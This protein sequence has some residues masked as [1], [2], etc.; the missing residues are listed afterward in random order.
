MVFLV[1]RSKSL[2][3]DNIIKYFIYI[4]PVSEIENEYC[5]I[6]QSYSDED[7]TPA[8]MLDDFT[9]IYNSIRTY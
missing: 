8:D 3:S 6:S 2:T 5:D 7:D 1:D 4:S 9:K